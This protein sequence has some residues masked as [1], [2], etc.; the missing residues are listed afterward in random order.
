MSMTYFESRYVIFP[1]VSVPRLLKSMNKLE[2]SYCR[3][4]QFFYGNGMV[5]FFRHKYLLKLIMGNIYLKK[6]LKYIL[7]SIK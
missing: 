7:I 4:Y 2:W 1:A 6:L 5:A 3:L